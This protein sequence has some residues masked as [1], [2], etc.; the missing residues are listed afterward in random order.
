MFR[1]KKVLDQSIQNQKN[2]DF[3]PS[4]IDSLLAFRQ[5]RHEFADR[6]LLVWSHNLSHESYIQI[7][8]LEVLDRILSNLESY[9]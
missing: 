4:T 1:L 3:L 2:T 7:E 5:I 9:L 8:Y 6:I